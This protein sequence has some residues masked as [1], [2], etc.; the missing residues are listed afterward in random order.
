MGDF[1]CQSLL[2]NLGQLARLPGEDQES[3]ITQKAAMLEDARMIY[4]AER[5][6][7]KRISAA[8]AECFVTSGGTAE[9][10]PSQYVRRSGLS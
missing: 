4:R 8:E 2:G 6:K 3:A 7:E 9:A 5:G 1:V 10:C